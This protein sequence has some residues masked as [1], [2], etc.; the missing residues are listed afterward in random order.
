MPGVPKEINL[1]HVA[2]V[3]PL[4]AYLAYAGLMEGAAAPPTWLYWLLAALAI[5]VL[6]FHWQAFQ[7]KSEK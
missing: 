4:L 3:A 2:F 6:L 7:K 1:F 5:G